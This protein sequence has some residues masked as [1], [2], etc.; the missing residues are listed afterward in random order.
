[1]ID[2]VAPGR[3]RLDEAVRL[4]AEVAAFSQ[5]PDAVVR[6]LVRPSKE[7]RQYADWA[8]IQFRDTDRTFEVLN[9]IAPGQKERSPVWQAQKAAMEAFRGDVP[10]AVVATLGDSRMFTVAS[11]NRS[12]DLLTIVGAGSTHVGIGTPPTEAHAVPTSGAGP[13][14][15]DALTIRPGLG[16]QR[17][18][19]IPTAQQLGAA[20]WYAVNVLAARE[21]LAVSDLMPTSTWREVDQQSAW[22]A[23]EVEDLAATTT[24]RVPRQEPFEDL[25]LYLDGT[26]MNREWVMSIRRHLDSGLTV[27][28]LPDDADSSPGPDDGQQVE[29]ARTVLVNDAGGVLQLAARL[30]RASDGRI[31]MRHLDGGS[32]AAHSVVRLLGIRE[33]ERLGV[34]FWYQGPQAYH[35]NVQMGQSI[36]AHARVVLGDRLDELPSSGWEDAGTPGKAANDVAEA[37]ARFRDT[38]GDVL[39]L[40][41][42]NPQ[43]AVLRDQVAGLMAEEL[44]GDETDP[45]LAAMWQAFNPKVGASKEHPAGTTIAVAITPDGEPLAAAGYRVAD[46]RIELGVAGGRSGAEDA[47]TAAIVDGPYRAGY[48]RSVGTFTASEIAKTYQQ[49]GATINTAPALDA[50]WL[51]NVELTRDAAR[52]IV[53]TADD[54]RPGL[55]PE[56]ADGFARGLKEFRESGA[57]LAVLAHADPDA[58]TRLAHLFKTVPSVLDPE[59]SGRPPALGE[60]DDDPHRTTVA[61]I[62]DGKPITWSTVD[63]RPGQPIEIIDGARKGR[64]RD[65]A[66]MDWWMANHQAR[67]GREL[68]STEPRYHAIYGDDAPI[69]EADW[70]LAATQH[71]IAGVHHREPDGM[72]AYAAG[73]GAEPPT[74]VNS[75]AIQLPAQPQQ[76]ESPA[77]RRPDRNRPDRGTSR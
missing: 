48:G 62:K 39:R 47:V 72:D 65:W 10:H 7:W 59:Q 58:R 38:G 50:E 68:R 43:Y 22:T 64:G 37:V 2:G 42:D 18:D 55:G 21:G 32:E 1:M 75:D 23:L 13:R 33:S 40:T 9:K 70:P 76:P 36:M 61:V 27:S 49:A 71:A 6:I 25:K 35:S 19:G 8:E 30:G 54:L 14:L 31:M 44:Q 26:S 16:G 73:A 45:G 51:T 34:G 24:S 4:A 63:S 29:G 60:E 17:T 52:K 3:G 11:F 67:L 56:R 57:Q 28:M 46:R 41:P 5:H 74:S 12:D 20:A 66:A 77:A 15:G 69:A 53:V